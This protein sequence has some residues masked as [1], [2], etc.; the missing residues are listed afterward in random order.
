MTGIKR[1]LGCIF[2]LVGILMVVIILALPWVTVND[3]TLFY[4]FIIIV[5]SFILMLIG[6]GLL[7]MSNRS[8]KS[9]EVE[10][11]TTREVPKGERLRPP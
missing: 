2:S 10:E 6:I 3:E 11:I 4:Y 7:R 1:G 8:A 9:E 5:I